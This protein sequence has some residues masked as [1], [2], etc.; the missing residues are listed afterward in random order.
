DR[1]PSLHVPTQINVGDHDECAPTLAEAMHKL[2]AGS[3][4]VVFP[5]SGHMTFVDQPKRFVDAVDGFLKRQ[6][7]G[8]DGPRPAATAAATADRAHNES[9]SR[10]SVEETP[11]LGGGITMTPV[12]RPDTLRFEPPGPGF[13]ELDPVHF[14]RPATRYW[15]E[16][17]P[18]PFQRGTG[19]FAR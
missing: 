15:I 2:I 7:A 18:D 14:P 13:W 9:F 16:V 12:E 8:Q 10:R 1:L 3:E 17:H 11:R 19:E 5:E 4:L 6:A